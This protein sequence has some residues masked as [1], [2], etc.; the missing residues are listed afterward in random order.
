MS[1]VA[2][3]GRGRIAVDFTGRT[4]LISGAEGMIGTAAARRFAAGGANL[5]FAGIGDLGATLQAVESYGVRSLTQEVDVTVQAQVQA[6][7]DRAVAEFGAVDVLVTVAGITSLG[8][9]SSITPQMW[10]KVHSVNLRGVFYCNQAI[11]P[12]MQKNGYGRIINV[13]SVLAKNGGNPRPWLDASEQ[14]G[15][16]NAAYG[17]A[18]A[19]VHALTLYLAKEL[20]VHGITVNAVAPGPIASQMT[21]SF[22]EALVKQLPVG[23]LGQADEVAAAIAFLAA[24]ESGFITG[25]ILDVNGGLWPD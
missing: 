6:V 2:G 19:G 11:I 15:A 25:E 7:V 10:E 1:V 4:V 14:A 21:A 3:Q 13:G 23:R 12:A 24:E 8:S 16:G 5:V 17:T 22:P 9:F 20:A 18:K